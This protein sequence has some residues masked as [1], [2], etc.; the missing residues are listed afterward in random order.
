MMPIELRAFIFEKSIKNSFM[1]N[2][3]FIDES[4]KP[5]PPEK[6]EDLNQNGDLKLSKNVSGITNNYKK[7]ENQKNAQ[8]QVPQNSRTS[9]PRKFLNPF[10]FILKDI[11]DTLQAHD[12]KFG[13]AQLEILA[14]FLEKNFI[15][16]LNFKECLLPDDDKCKVIAQKLFYLMTEQ[17]ITFL[18]RN[19]SYW[20]KRIYSCI[21]LGSNVPL[22]L[23]YEQTQKGITQPFKV[24][25]YDWVWR[26]T[27]ET[28]QKRADEQELQKQQLAGQKHDQ[29]AENNNANNQP[30]ELDGQQPGGDL[31]F[32]QQSANLNQ[33]QF[34]LSALP[35][36][37][38]GTGDQSA[39]F[40][41]LFNQRDV[42]QQML[43]S[44]G[45]G[46]LAGQ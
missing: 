3:D 10:Y 33:G 46:F 36:L 31:Q 20:T 23:E 15:E 38:P 11:E 14:T 37:A 19:I 22:P 29:L 30:G 44:Q 45:A 4:N 6:E 24:I 21:F 25:E 27:E 13:A 39:V 43:A 42:M 32:N 7:K 41:N 9:V 16:K 35:G 1:F 28:Q 17:P 5:V 34:D 40:N 12:F 26:D 18:D 8:Q 2:R